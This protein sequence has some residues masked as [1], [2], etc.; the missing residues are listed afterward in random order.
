MKK[1]Y[2][3]PAVLLLF[4]FLFMAC[5]NSE[6]ISET[7][8]MKNAKALKADQAKNAVEKCATSQ[9]GTIVDYSGET[10]G[11]GFNE[12][13]YNYQ[14]Q[15]YAGEPYAEPHEFAGWYLNSK[16]N[17]GWLST[18]DCS[19]N[20][21]LDTSYYNA[22]GSGAWVTNHWSFKHTVEDKECNITI[23]SKY[24]AV[25][26]GAYIDGD[27]YYNEDDVEIGRTVEG[28]VDFALIQYIENNPCED[29]KGLQYKI[30]GPVGLGNR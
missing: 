6:D 9:G 23:F 13:G 22:Q 5:D 30:P 3:F 12:E 25:P 18:Q 14:G 17:D 28:L 20:G 8:E 16:W 10:I 29:I 11:L 15:S 2:L 24:A 1:I 21:S 19:G 26:V 27:F 7:I 4:T